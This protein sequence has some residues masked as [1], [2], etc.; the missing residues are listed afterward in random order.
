VL[1]FR[2]RRSFS[3][4]NNYLGHDFQRKLVWL[5]MLIIL[6]IIIFGQWSGKVPSFEKLFRRSG[7]QS[8]NRVVPSRTLTDPNAVDALVRKPDERKP[9]RGNQGEL[10]LAGEVP[11]VPEG[12]AKPVATKEL[13]GGAKAEWFLGLEDDAVFRRDENEAFFALLKLLSDSD[14]KDIRLATTGLRTFRQLYDQSDFYRGDIV[15][16]RGKVRRI[17]PYTNNPPNEQE[18]KKH[19]QVW[20]EPY[21]NPVPIVAVCTQIPDDFPAGEEGIEAEI[22]GF[23]YKR[24]GYASAEQGDVDP[25]TGRRENVFRSSPLVL[26]KTIS[27]RRTM[28]TAAADEP[29][30]DGPALPLGIPQKYAFQ[31]IGVGIM[32][33]IMIAYWS[34][35]MSR[36]SV[37][38]RGPI[39]GRIRRQAEEAEAEP[40]D[41]NN[42]RF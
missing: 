13:F 4:K 42:L 39:V 18:I 34:Y 23:F 2:Q 6:G 36:T 28:P 32:L 24:L 33:M 7:P 11:S 25:A 8:D 22:S 29:A 27:W 40:T 15:T 1:T 16:V 31:V 19:Y 37:L 12:A 5:A 3:G 35:R 9:G 21:G 30:A 38:A 26:A 10:A 20:I 41:L 14:E 17:T